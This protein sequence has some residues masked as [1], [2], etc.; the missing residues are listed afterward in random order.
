MD[1]HKGAKE[2]MIGLKNAL[3]R[4]LD[5]NAKGIALRY[6]KGLPITQ[7]VLESILNY[8]QQQKLKRTTKMIFLIL[9]IIHQ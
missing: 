4:A 7:N 5:E 3:I 6:E 8:I 9:P 2:D 1:T